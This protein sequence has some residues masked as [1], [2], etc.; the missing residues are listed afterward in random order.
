MTVAGTW[1]VLHVEIA[2]SSVTEGSQAAND[3][4]VTPFVASI[5]HHLSSQKSTQ[6]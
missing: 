2:K 1:H 5:H 3:A 6:T 4:L